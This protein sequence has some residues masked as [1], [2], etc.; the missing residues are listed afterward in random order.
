MATS[1]IIP[2]IPGTS[3]ATSTDFPIAKITENIWN[4]KISNVDVNT[5]SVKNTDYGIAKITNLVHMSTISETLP[6]RVKFT[7]VG[8]EGFVV[9]PIGIAIIGFNNYIL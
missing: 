7:N 4:T 2:I 5:K 8:I 1:K 3:K 9:P 6:F